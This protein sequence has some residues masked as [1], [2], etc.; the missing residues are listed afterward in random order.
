MPRRAVVRRRG[1]GRVQHDAARAGRRREIDRFD[2]LVVGADIADM[3][4]CEGDDLS[5]IGGIG[6][7]LLI[8]RHR[9][10]E[11]D[12]ADRM[13]GGAEAL[14]FKD[15]AVGKDDERRRFGLGPTV[16]AR[17][18]PLVA[19]N[20]GLKSGLLG[21]GL[22][23]TRSGQWLAAQWF[24]PHGLLVAYCVSCGKRPR[25][26]NGLCFSA[27]ISNIVG[28]NSKAASRPLGAR[29]TGFCRTPL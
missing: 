8:T 24:A 9:G 1:D 22:P 17:L 7:D 2:V 11:A 18:S 12:L 20:S 13:A 25:W 29:R 15:G 23:K 21:L 19:A 27:R 16:T 14:S 10:V 6:E 3:R 4:E 5:G 26:D 28:N